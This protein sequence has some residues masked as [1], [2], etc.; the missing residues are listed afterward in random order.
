MP[1]REV[2]SRKPQLQRFV[3]AHHKSPQLLKSELCVYKLQWP[4]CCAAPVGVRFDTCAP[5]CRESEEQVV[6]SRRSVAECTRR[7]SQVGAGVAGW[8]TAIGGVSSGGFRAAHTTGGWSI[9]RSLENAEDVEPAC[10]RDALSQELRRN[11]APKAR[12]WGGDGPPDLNNVPPL[13][14]DHQGIKGRVEECEELRS[15]GCLEF[16]F[17]DVIS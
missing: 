1:T 14:D 9:G 8:R 12:S 10:K 5:I 17:A 3:E 16:G 15:A 6:Q 7:T 4:R 11:R 13:P 2:R